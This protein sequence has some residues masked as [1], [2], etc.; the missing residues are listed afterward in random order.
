MLVAL[1]IF[2]GA[3][4]ENKV[5][6]YSNIDKDILAKAEEIYESKGMKTS[7]EQAARMPEQQV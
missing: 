2:L 5:E 1:A 7:V 4:I 6:S 3:D